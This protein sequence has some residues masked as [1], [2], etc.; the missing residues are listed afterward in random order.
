MRFP[1]PERGAQPVEEEVLDAQPYLLG[2]GGGREV[3]GDVVQEGG[4]V[5]GWRHDEGY[6]ENVSERLAKNIGSVMNAEVEAGPFSLRA[7][8]WCSPKSTT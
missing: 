4:C 3:G 5:F 8:C 1:R 6:C 7:G 2:D